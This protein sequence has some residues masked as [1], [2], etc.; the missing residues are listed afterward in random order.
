MCACVRSL[1][2]ASPTGL[3]ST[4]SFFP[5]SDERGRLPVVNSQ[6]ESIA[7]RK[8]E[9]FPWTT[10]SKSISWKLVSFEPA[11]VKPN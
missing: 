2:E 4:S 9:D 10:G 1:A 5:A 7:E 11:M 8:E 6:L 3:P